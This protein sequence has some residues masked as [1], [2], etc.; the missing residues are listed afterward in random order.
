LTKGRS[1]PTCIHCLTYADYKP[2][3]CSAHLFP[4]YPEP[5]IA[6]DNYPKYVAV[7][8]GV[9][10]G[11][12]NRLYSI[13]ESF[14]FGIRNNATSKLA[15]N[16]WRLKYYANDRFPEIPRQVVKT[17]KA[18][19]LGESGGDI[20]EGGGGGGGGG[21]DDI[22]TGTESDPIEVGEIVECRL[23]KSEWSRC[24]I[25][26]VRAMQMYDIKYDTGEELRFVRQQQIR[27]RAEKREYAYRLELSI[28]NI[29]SEKKFKK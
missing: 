17:D 12:G 26:K 15:A 11:A 18:V 8:G 16:D 22:D 27:L 6:F 29:F 13:I 19:A 10:A 4:H 25:I 7:Q 14:I 21:G 2:P 24:R 23:Q 1:V 9:K 20:E 28:V 5:H 3:M